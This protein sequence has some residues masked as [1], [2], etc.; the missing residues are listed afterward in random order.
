MFWHQ[1]VYLSTLSGGGPMSRWGGVPGLRFSGGSGPRSQIFGRGGPRSQ[2][3]G[4]SQVS[5]FGGRG[6]PGLTFFLGGVPSL[7]KGKNVWHQIWLDTCSDWEKHFLSRDPPP[8]S[9][10]KNFW[11]QIWLD[12]CSDWQ[13]KFCRGS[14]PPSKGKIFWHQIWLDTCSDWKKIFVKGPPAPCNSKKLLWLC[15]G[16][17]ASCVHA[18]GL[19]CSVLLLQTLIWSKMWRFKASK[20]KN[21]APKVPKKEVTRT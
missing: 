15:G 8:P 10:G 20:Y 19:S 1:S 2:I 14:P 12:T 11:H 7:S 13:K 3:F 5:D 4:G 17:Y 18:G 16:R 21:A 9:K 6:V